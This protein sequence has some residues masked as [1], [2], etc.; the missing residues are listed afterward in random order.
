MTYALTTRY[1]KLETVLGD[2][3]IPALR[4]F[5]PFGPTP[6]SSEALALLSQIGGRSAGVSVIGNLP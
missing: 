5:H 4:R 1:A 6:L 2:E 3:R